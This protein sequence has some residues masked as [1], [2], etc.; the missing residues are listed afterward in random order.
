MLHLRF[1]LIIFLLNS[2]LTCLDLSCCFIIHPSMSHVEPFRSTRQDKLSLKLVACIIPSYVP[3]YKECI[4]V[5]SHSTTF[6]SRHIQLHEHIF[7]YTNTPPSPS[8]TIIL[9][10]FSTDQISPYVSTLSDPNSSIYSDLLPLR[11]I[12]HCHL[13]HSLP[14]HHMVTRTHD[15][16][17]RPKQFLDHFLYQAWLDNIPDP[18]PTTFSQP[19]NGL[20]GGMLIEEIS[21]LILAWL[22]Y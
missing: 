12:L 16:T 9:P 3:H 7:P 17:C 18:E 2:C 19:V 21:A 5:F 15:H 14:T 22:W 13:Y 11:L 8:S 10:S 4:C 6:T 20:Y 1:L